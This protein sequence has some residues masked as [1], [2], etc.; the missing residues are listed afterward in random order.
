MKQIDVLI[1]GAGPAGSVCGS[2]L[3]QAGVECVIVDQATFPRDKVCGGGLTVKAWRLLDHL[4]PGIE[5]DYRPINRMR[6]QFEDDPVCEFRSE[7]E[8]RMTR[9]KDFDHT[10]LKYYQEHGGELIKG[11]FARFEQQ[12]DGRI[13]VTLKSGDQI[14]CRYLVA[15]DGANS[16]IRKQMHGAPKLHALF[17]EQ[18]NEGETDD[19]VFVH[20]SKNYKPGV[21]YKFSS[22]GRDMYGF[23]A[24]ESNEDFPRHAEKFRQTLTAFGVPVGHTRGAYIPLNTVQ[25]TVDHV[26]LIGDAGGFANKLT[27]EGL[28]DAFKTAANAA[29]AIV[30]D[31]PFTE[32]NSEVFRKMEHQVHVFKF[33]FSPYG[34]R[35]IRW[36]MRHPRLIKWL[37]DAKMKRETFFKNKK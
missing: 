10:L 37:F 18:Y 3:R 32:T 25:S 16:L 23:A 28:Y 22:K 17:L 19:D 9:R 24:L 21:F 14:S 6:C 7:Y 31:K 36:G 26:I 29:R 34:W 12:T 33:F 1:V 11:S 35:L 15:A 2:L 30:E 8:I 20:F 13:L 5:Y 4:M 27:G